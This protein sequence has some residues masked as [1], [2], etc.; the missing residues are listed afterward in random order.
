MKVPGF[1][2]AQTIRNKDNEIPSQI[3]QRMGFSEL[4]RELD[5]SQFRSSN[6][7]YCLEIETELL[8]PHIAGSTAKLSVVY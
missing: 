3:A 4:S 7:K 2:I 1:Q 6:C 8:K 5:V